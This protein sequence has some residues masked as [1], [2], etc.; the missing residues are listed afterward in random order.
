MAPV[1]GIILRILVILTLAFV[2]SNCLTMIHTKAIKDYANARREFDTEI[3]KGHVG[4]AKGVVRQDG[5]TVVAVFPQTLQGP[6]R[7]LRLEGKDGALRL[8]EVSASIEGTPALILRQN[9]C[10]ME[11]AALRAVIFA[12]PGDVKTADAIVREAFQIKDAPSANALGV[13][14]FTNVYTVSAY[15]IL[16]E[17]GTIKSVSAL[18][19]GDYDPAMSGI[20]WNVRS[21]P[22][23]VLMHLWYGVTVPLD[24]VTSPFQLVAILLLPPGAR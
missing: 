6:G 4:M 14:D 15:L 2:S 1:S 16:S 19:P 3:V 24:I 5:S 8:S 20:D 10:C 21:R 23:Y 17:N 9:V 18:P 7:L 22:G 11:D 12:Q 13:I